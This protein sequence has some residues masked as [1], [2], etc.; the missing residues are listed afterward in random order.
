MVKREFFFLVKKGR[1]DYQQSAGEMLKKF[2]SCKVILYRLLRLDKKE[3]S[4]DILCEECRDVYNCI[5]TFVWC[6]PSCYK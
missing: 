3:K 2:P 4:L 1:W 5:H 6:M